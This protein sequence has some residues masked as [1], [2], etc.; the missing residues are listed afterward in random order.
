M[1]GR[2]FVV[3]VF[4]GLVMNVG[5]GTHRQAAAQAPDAVVIAQSAD[6]QTGDPH[7]TVAIHAYNALINVYDTLM[8]RDADLR[9][10]PGLALAW[11]AI[12]P[13]TWELDL[14]RGVRFH[15]GEPFNAQAVKFSL[16]RALDPRTKWPGAG[17][18][19]P[20]KSVTVVNDHTLRI[21]T[22]RPWPF[23]PAHMAY[24]GWI[25]PPRHIERA[26]EEALARRPVGTGPYRFVRWIKDE[27]VELEVNSGYWGRRPKI[28][29]VIIR[30]IPSESSRLA[31]LLAGSV[32]LINIVP[33]EVFGPILRS[34][35]ARLVSGRSAGIFYL[36][37]N[38]MNIPRDRPL[39]DRRVRQA[40]NYAVDRKVMIQSIL[41]NVGEVVPTLCAD[42]S[43]GCDASVPP[44]PYDPDRA[45]ALL[46]ETGYVDGFD[47][48]ISSTSGGYP[49]DLDLSLAVA[50]QFQRVGVRARVVVIEYG[51]HLR[52]IFSRNVPEHAMFRRST[53]F[54]GY[55]GGVADRNFH[56]RGGTSLWSPGRRDFDQLLETAAVTVDEQRMK[57]LYRRAQLVF[58]EEAPAVPL[59]TAP[60][61]HGLHRDLEWTPRPDL[62]LT[63][64][65]A[66]WRRR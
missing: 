42:I 59:F 37:F 41:H 28:E 51:V 40:L 38:L 12:E 14:R 50:D 32:H 54:I 52:Q 49:A 18:L 15:N 58:K 5:G 35:R 61:A 39:A 19:R 24:Y 48:T 8:A 65:D 47:M 56:S 3:L 6:I 63:M 55:A 31:E 29:R 17:V 36:Q 4:L 10:K 57:D 25:V 30:A 20:I 60:N 33:P 11:R 7:K 9:V 62:L 27:R 53:D 46:R 23:F 13:T 1:R 2:W 44:Y 22:E 64:A 34:A 21:A 43:T 26:G 16:E 66:S 45:R